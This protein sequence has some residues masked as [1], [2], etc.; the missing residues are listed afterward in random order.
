MSDIHCATFRLYPKKEQEKIMLLF[1]DCT[2]NVY[3][4]LTEICKIHMEKHLPLPSKFDLNNMAKK[5]RHRNPEMQN[6]HSH[7]FQSIA[8]RVHNAFISWIKRNKDGTGFPRFKTC[9]MFDS[10]TYA[11]NTDYSFVGKNGEKCKRKLIRLGM[12]G[13]I[14]FSNPFIIKGECKTATVYRRKMG[15]HFEW[16]ISITYENKD[17]RKD[18]EF[19]DPSITRKDIGIDMGLENLATLSDGTVIPNDHTYT[20]KEK[21][22]AKAQRRLSRY[23]K[24][25]PE[26]HRQWSRL[27]HKFK[28]LRNH[29]ND[30][31]HK[32]SMNLCEYHRNIFM[33]D[34]SVKKMTENSPKKMRKSFRDAGWGIFTRMISYKVEETGNS[35]I[36]VNPAYTSQLC[37]SCGTLVP[38]DLSI[39]VHVCPNCGLTISRDVNA[40]I[41][42]LNRGLGLQTEAGNCLKCNEG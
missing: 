23:E 24:D 41:N 1:L 40:A 2:R 9:K 17:F 12:I 36:F 35:V 28:K 4:R 11:Q 15:T 37:S 31:F 20:N 27:A 10:F 26:Y 8:S 32:I 5:I 3:N 42:I 22:V 34:L 30:M 13:L 19:I 33:E 6:V 29:R 16:F 25:T 39:R 14:K 7:C 38:K 18:T 21:D